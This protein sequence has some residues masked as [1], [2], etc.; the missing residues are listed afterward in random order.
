MGAGKGSEV[1]RLPIWRN[2]KTVLMIGGDDVWLYSTPLLQP[3]ESFRM[4]NRGIE[5]KEGAKT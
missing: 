4:G 3:F 1:G 5:N 2:R